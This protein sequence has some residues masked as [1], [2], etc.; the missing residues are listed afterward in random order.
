MGLWNRIGAYNGVGMCTCYII[1]YIVSQLHLI[2]ITH[3]S[4]CIQF[5]RVYTLHVLLTY[6]VLVVVPLR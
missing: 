2:L 6:T 1:I 4:V 5:L 3:M